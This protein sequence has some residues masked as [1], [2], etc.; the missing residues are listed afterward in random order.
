MGALASA[1]QVATSPSGVGAARTATSCVRRAHGFAPVGEGVA[2][3]A[4]FAPTLLL[5]RNGSTARRARRRGVRA[6][7]HADAVRRAVVDEALALAARG[8][9]SLVG[10]LVTRD[11]RSRRRSVPRGGWHGRMLVSTRGG[12][13][14]RPATARRCRS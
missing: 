8:K 11:P 13:P 2:N 6:G 7:Q 10:T 14:S 4:F 9:G 3:G 1:A 5:C 12:R